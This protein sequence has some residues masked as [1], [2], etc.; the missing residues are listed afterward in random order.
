MSRITFA[1][2]REKDVINLCDGSKLGCIYEIEFDTCS[3]QL[4]SLI[5]S[6][7]EGMFS[8]LRECKLTLPW[9]R[10]E[11]IGDDAVLVKISN[12]EIE[13]FFKSD[14]KRRVYERDS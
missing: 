3:G 13:S 11:C 2:L 10:I 4:C 8:F 12:S 9:N 6:R 5:V 1:Q 14:R 7:S